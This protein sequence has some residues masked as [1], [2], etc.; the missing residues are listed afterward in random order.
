M[1]IYIHIVPAVFWF[2]LNISN[3]NTNWSDGNGKAVTHGLETKDGPPVHPEHQHH[4]ENMIFNTKRTIII[5]FSA[6]GST[7]SFTI[8]FM[9]VFNWPNDMNVLTLVLVLGASWYLTPFHPSYQSAS[10]SP[11]SWRNLHWWNFSENIPMDSCIFYHQ[12]IHMISSVSNH[13]CTLHMFE[14]KLCPYSRRWLYDW[15]LHQWQLASACLVSFSLPRYFGQ[16]L[17]CTRGYCLFRFARIVL[18]RPKDGL[19]WW[20]AF[21]EHGLKQKKMRFV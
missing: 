21:L 5:S 19:M 7:K 8:C 13:V 6:L 10:S 4:L 18:H 9:Q 15:P 14:K 12:Y 1:Y 11:M 17:Q 2:G 16:V 3:L 20:E